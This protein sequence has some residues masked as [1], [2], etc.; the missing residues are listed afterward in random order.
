MIAQRMG[1]ESPELEQIEL[2]ALLHDVGKVGVPDA[3]I[4][5]AGGLNDEE[6]TKI[7]E[8]PII[9]YQLLWK[10]QF[11]RGAAPVVKYHHER[12]DGSGYPEG[13]CGKSIPIGARIFAVVDTFDV[14][15]SRRAYKEE[16]SIAEAQEEINR[17]VG[18]QFDPKVV[19]VFNRVRDEELL[20]IRQRVESQFGE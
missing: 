14:I 16:K 17:C 10:H 1:V 18:T 15:I 4:R 7:R 13:L 3:I 20:E 9:G 12:Y 2:G 5:K 19:E 8:H 11:L 6:W